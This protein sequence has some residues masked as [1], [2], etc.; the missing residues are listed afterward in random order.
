MN[1][2]PVTVPVYSGV[3]ISGWMDGQVPGGYMAKR[4]GG[5]AV[6][7][8][9]FL[10][11]APASA[12]MAVASSGLDRVVAGVV[13]CRLAIGMAQG[14]FIPAA[15]SMLGHWIPPAHRGRHFAFAMSGMYAGTATAMVTVPPLG[16]PPQSQAISMLIRWDLRR[17]E[18]ERS[19]D[20]ENP[21]YSGGGLHRKIV[22]TPATV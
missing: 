19:S 1:R 13:T 6:L 20:P 15:Q 4:F 10:L 12:L 18:T 11:W 8:L 17:G 14:V 21:V 5:K 2:R 9:S 3:F 16:E 22:P 7:A